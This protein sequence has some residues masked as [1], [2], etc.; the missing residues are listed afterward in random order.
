MAERANKQRYGDEVPEDSKLAFGA[1]QVSQDQKDRAARMW[2]MLEQTVDLDA[3][4]EGYRENKFSELGFTVEGLR[5]SMRMSKKFILTVEGKIALGLEPENRGRYSYMAFRKDLVD[6]FG[7][8][9]DQERNTPV[10][11]VARAGAR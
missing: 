1:G 5:G 10:H 4:F 2:E 7:F 6:E 11:Q 3:T 9:T 8:G